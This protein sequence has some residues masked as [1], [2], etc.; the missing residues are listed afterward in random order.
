MLEPDRAQLET[1]IGTLFRHAGTDGYI[2]LRAFYEDEA[3]KPARIM[4]TGLKGG[5]PFVFDAAEDEARRAANHPK[6]I[7]FCPPIAVFSNPKTARE[8]DILKGLALSVECDQRPREALAKLE[9]IL[10]QPT[11]IVASG[12]K[13]EDPANGQIHDKLHIHWRLSGPATGENIAKLKQV[14]DIAT[15]L[16]GGDPTNIPACHPIRWAGS[17]HRKK[18]DVLCQIEEHHPEREIDLDAALK[19]LLAMAPP[20]YRQEPPKA[21]GE[22]HDNLF[23]AYGAQHGGGDWDALVA[24]ILAGENLHDSINR[25]AAMA[26]SNGMSA[27]TI[28]QM[29]RGL[30]NA[31]AA[32]KD[33]RWQ[34]RYNDIVRA[35]TTAE[36]KFRAPPPGTEQTK[37][38]TARIKLSSEFIAGF[39]P[40][41]YVVEGI[42]Q[43]AF[44]YALTGATGAGKTCLTLLLAA[45]VALGEVFAGRET[46]KLRVLYLAAENPDD[47]RMRWIALAQAMGFDI[48][49]IEVYFIEGCFKISQAGKWLQAEAAARGGEFG[50][51]VID[52]SPAF[53]EGDDENSRT[54]MGNH[55]R[56]L[57]GLIN[58]IPGKP[59]V[60][61]N[62][63]PVKNANADNLLP[64]GGGSFLNEVDGNLTAAKTDST[65]ELHWQGKYR[66]PEFAPMNFLIKTVTHQD[67]KDGKGNLIPTVICEWMSDETKDNIAKAVRMDQD[68]VLKFISENPTA[69]NASIAI[70]MKWKLYNG[71]PNKMKASRCVKTLIKHKLIKETRGGQYRLDRAGEKVLKGEVDE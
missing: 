64:A 54:Q 51:V 41:D 59:C 19:A 49:T 58:L 43:Q 65:S 56:V 42:L 46:K 13:W 3:G 45:S 48:D 40:P 66:G 12:G 23:S 6:S 22:S 24:N 28:V 36:Q 67:L 5:L 61:A 39:V 38:A 7:V 32:P 25:L 35:V 15:R 60:V 52:T 71:G 68:A 70:A 4:P 31:S 9:P 21:N 37:N 69:S 8:I 14:R 57:R 44:L 63:H 62:C 2:S 29:L 33:A 34:A 30:M 18:G 47:V 11:L 10:G 16:V 55:A 1:F 27:V 53:Y 50:L 17:W 20:G 26:V